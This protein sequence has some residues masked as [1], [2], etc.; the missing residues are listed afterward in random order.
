MR[1]A[2]IIGLLLAILA[3]AAFY[4]LLYSPKSEEQ[5]ALEAETQQFQAQ[6]QDLR[7]QIAQ[8][9][10]IEARQVEIR[11]QLAR[12]EE[13]IPTGIAQPSIVRQFQLQADAA[14]VAILS[15][16]FGEPVAVVDAPTTGLP[17][18]S[19]VQIPVTMVVDGGYFQAVDFF[20]R[21]EFEVTRAILVQN[22]NIAEAED[23]FPL[24]STTWGGQLFAVAP[25]VPAAAPA[26]A[27]GSTPEPGETPAPG[28]TPT[29]A[30]AGGAS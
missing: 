3:G 27:P 7:N 26:P 15:V 23:G 2:P 24:L 19:L 4:F 21:L 18:T 11:A 5:A 25:V 9:R 12:L 13:Y 8:L 17:D 10:D 29:D 14:G 20:R 16:T 6:A 30:A 28:A 1:R 22:V